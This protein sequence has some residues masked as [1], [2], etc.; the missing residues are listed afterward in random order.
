MKRP[1]WFDDVLYAVWLFIMVGIPACSSP[2][3]RGGAL[4][5][6]RPGL[7]LAPRLRYSRGP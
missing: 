5:R 7:F 6:L 2:E 4:T 3:S 1:E